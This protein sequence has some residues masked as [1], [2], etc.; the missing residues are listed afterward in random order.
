MSEFEYRPQSEFNN[1]IGYLTRIDKLFYIIA[2]CKMTKPID[3]YNWM[4]ALD[5]LFTELSTEMKDDEI[6][7][8]K[9]FLKSLKDAVGQSVNNRNYTKGIVR[10]DVVDELR[11]FELFLRKIYKD[12]GLQMRMQ[13]DAGKAY[14]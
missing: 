2:E 1:A 6:L 9:E 5:A 11:N 7:K 12:S 4:M 10:S 8:A 14:G 3:V 13:Q